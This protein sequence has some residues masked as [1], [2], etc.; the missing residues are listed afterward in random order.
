MTDK[1]KRSG[2]DTEEDR[3]EEEALRTQI[4]N[5]FFSYTGKLLEKLENAD[6]QEGSA[7]LHE[8]GIAAEKAREYGVDD[9]EIRAIEDAANMVADFA[10]GLSFLG[11][12]LKGMA[13]GEDNKKE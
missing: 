10:T 1:A 2:I 12:I 5:I 8:I 6:A 4:K 13:K 3:L 7:I 9:G 11:D